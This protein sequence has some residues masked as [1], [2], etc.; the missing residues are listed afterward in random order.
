MIIIITTMI[1]ITI[2]VLI[3]S[4]SRYHSEQMVAVNTMNIHQALFQLVTFT[5]HIAHLDHSITF[6]NDTLRRN[7]K[8]YARWLHLWLIDAADDVVLPGRLWHAVAEAVVVRAA[9]HH[10]PD[11]TL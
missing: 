8:L 1:I 2:I 9:A 11:E 7:E 5:L 3:D 4:Y 10:R 6:I